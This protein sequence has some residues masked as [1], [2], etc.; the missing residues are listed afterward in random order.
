MFLQYIAIE[1][2]DVDILTKD[3]SRGNL[4]FHRCKIGLV[5]NHFI[6]QR[7]C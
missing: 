7:E 4:K 5:D 1:E 2:E 6:A 3:L